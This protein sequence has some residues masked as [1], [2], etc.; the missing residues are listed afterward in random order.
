MIRDQRIR[1]TQTSAAGLFAPR[2]AGLAFSGVW[3][4]ALLLGVV[5]ATAGCKKKVQAAAP[6]PPNATAQTDA[7]NTA[8]TSPQ[9]P[10][11]TL[12][13]PQTALTQPDGQPDLSALDHTL[14]RWIV[15][16]RRKP[17]SFEQFAATAGVAIPPPP[18]GKKYFI[19]KDMHIVLVNR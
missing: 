16:N 1:F 5:L 10:V 13:Q 7:G 18:A 14:L 9:A 8:P 17:A 11:Q 19:G 2:R 3:V 6:P 12:V 4:L 15:A